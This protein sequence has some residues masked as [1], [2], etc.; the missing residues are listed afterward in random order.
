MGK[1]SEVKDS[2]DRY[3]SFTTE[4]D[5]DAQ[6]DA[7]KQ[8]HEAEHGQRLAVHGKRP[9]GAGKVQVTFR[10]VSTKGGKG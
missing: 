7:F 8:E 3:F 6:I 9:L 4:A 2:H 10:V 1:R 5:L